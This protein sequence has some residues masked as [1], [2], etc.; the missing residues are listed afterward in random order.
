MC[1]YRHEYFVMLDCIFIIMNLAIPTKLPKTSDKTEA[2][3][4]M[5]KM[6]IKRGNE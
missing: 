1:F 3:I 6:G 4:T 5:L 2:F